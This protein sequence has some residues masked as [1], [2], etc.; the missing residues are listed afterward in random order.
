MKKVIIVLLMIISIRLNASSW[1]SGEILIILNPNVRGNVYDDFVSSYSQYGLTEVE[2]IST[3]LNLLHFSFKPSSIDDEVLLSLIRQDPRV[4]VAQLNHFYDDEDIEVNYAPPENYDDGE[5]A[6]NIPNDHYFGEQWALHNTG[7]RVNGASGSVGADIKAL[8]A[9]EYIESLSNRNQRTPIVAVLDT[10]F[11]QDHQDLIG[12]FVHGWNTY[13]DN[14]ILPVDNHGT[15]VSGIIIATSNNGIGISGISG[16]FADI[17][18]M[19]IYPY[20]F[21]VGSLTDD[22]LHRAY[23]YVLDKRLEYNESN[24]TEGFYIVATNQSFGGTYNPNDFPISKHLLDVMGEAGIIS[25]MSA[26]NDGLNLNNNS[27]VPQR[28]ETEYKIV[29]ANSTQ[30]DD[31]SISSNFGNLTVDISAPGSNIYSTLTSDRYGFLSG[32]SMAAPYV[33]GVLALIYSAISEDILASYDNNPGELALIIKQSILNGVQPLSSLSGK[34]IT[35]GRLDAFQAILSILYD[36]ETQSLTGPS[37]ANVYDTLTYTVQVTN[38]RF[39]AVSGNDYTVQFRSSSLIIDSVQGVDLEPG[40]SHVF[41][42][43]WTPTEASQY[44]MNGMIVYEED[45]NPDNNTTSNLVVTVQTDFIAIAPTNSLTLSQ[46]LPLIAPGGTIQM[47][48][49]YYDI[50]TKHTIANNDFNLIGSDDESLP[51]YL[52]SWFSFN[53][54]GENMKIENITFTPN[55][56]SNFEYIF[57]LFHSSPVFSNL[58]FNLNDHSQTIAIYIENE[59]FDS[60]SSTQI[61]NCTFKGGRGIYYYGANDHESALM[62]TNSLFDKNYFIPYYSSSKIGNAIEFYGTHLTIT[63]SEFIQNTGNYS[64]ETNTRAVHT[65]YADIMNYFSYINSEINIT[66]NRFHTQTNNASFYAND[67]VFQVHDLYDINIERNIFQTTRLFGSVNPINRV[68]VHCS[69]IP[70]N[71]ANT[72]SVINNTDLFAENAANGGLVN[73]AFL[74]HDVKLLAKNNLFTGKISSSLPSAINHIYNSLFVYNS[75]PYPD[76][77]NTIAVDIHYGN[78]QIDENLRPLW[79]DTVK[80]VLIDGGHRDTNSNGIA[81]F[82]DPADRDTDKTRLDIGAVYYP[83]GVIYHWLIAPL[84]VDDDDNVGINPR[85]NDGHEWVSFPFLDKLY[86]TP[87]QARASYVFGPHNDNNLFGVNN[88]SAR[89]LDHISWNYND[90]E[91]SISWNNSNNQ[92]TNTDHV[93]R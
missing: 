77:N 13:N 65:V 38:I 8:N 59:Y 30:N 19:P 24:G 51:T 33:S 37:V 36:L 70:F 71:P 34:T 42:F 91:N 41:N 53:N 74:T 1:V 55:L 72:I 78:P 61:I 93:Y 84:A 40:Q 76:N 88:N 67:I 20:S 23:L 7:Q 18:V 32:T 45:A 11:Q 81:W 31:L 29:V 66:G 46:A 14:S 43:E 60:D 3:R 56:N 92:W 39:S 69:L 73:Y 57:Q 83:H 17:N 86:D 2:V 25:I 49:G 22:L 90:D 52:N 10:G 62:V 12:N 75:N 44:F 54:V 82:T 85:G 89:F 5:S 87:N 27:R 16:G 28:L 9:W 63:D 50:P 64:S 68:V 26:G 79:T 48:G 15:H 6:R 47:A 58:T 4:N 35:G 80:S 21:T